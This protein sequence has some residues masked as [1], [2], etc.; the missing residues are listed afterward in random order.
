M[1]MIEYEQEF[2][3]LSNYS[4]ECVSS[5]AIMCKRFEDGLNE[6]IRLAIRPIR[7]CWP[8]M[9]YRETRAFN[10]WSKLGE[11]GE[12]RLIKYGKKKNYHLSLFTHL[13]LP[14]IEEEIEHL[15]VQTF[16]E[17]I[18]L[19]IKKSTELTL[20]GEKARLQI[21]PLVDAF[22]TW[23]CKCVITTLDG[24]LSVI[25]PY[26]L[27]MIGCMRY[28]RLYYRL[29]GYVRYHRNYP[30]WWA[31]C[32]TTLLK[33]DGGLSAKPPSDLAFVKET[34]QDTQ[35][36]GRST[37]LSASLEYELFSDVLNGFMLGELEG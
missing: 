7:M 23:I 16:S 37:T 31:M 20:P 34:G 10:F 3:R 32:D 35:I 24:G 30:F 25:P 36:I 13:F 9:W 28:H 27:S 33:I 4:R 26:Y 6:D 22:C 18:S 21:K 5:E 2:F 17:A 11:L 12:K 8:A 1:S 29:V 19:L 14:R 15:G